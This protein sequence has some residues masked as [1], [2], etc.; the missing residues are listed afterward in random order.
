MKKIN[1]KDKEA[2]LTKHKVLIDA[3]NQLKDEFVGLDIIIDEVIDLVEPWY[4]FPD[5]QLRPS[6]INLFGMTGTG[7]TSLITRLFEILEM[8]SVLRFDT[9]E[10]VEKTEYQLSSTISGQIKKLKSDDARPIF[11]LDEFQLGRTID[12]HGAEIDRPNLR[13]V[14][15]LLDSGKFSIVEE[16]WQA[17]AV[18]S[19]YNKL[20]YL[21]EHKGLKAKNGKITKG[22]KDWELYFEYNDKEL[23]KDDLIDL[24]SY[25]TNNGI[26]PPNELYSLFDVSDR[27]FSERE[28]AKFLLTLTNEQSTLK[29]VE[30]VMVNASKA[31]EYDFSNSIIFI[32]GNLDGA[33]EMSH[34][35]D[36]DMDADF[37]YE[38]TKKIT[39][40]DIKNSLTDLYRPEQVS[41]L[42][43]N[44]IIYR[45]FNSDTYKDLIDLELIK[46]QNKINKKFE[47]DINFTDKTK[48]LIYKEGVFATQGVRP[49]FSTITSLIETKI[50]RVIIDILK[51][52]INANVIKWDTNN[53]K[54]KF[55]LTIDDKKTFEYELKLKVDNLRKSIGDDIQ[56]LV[57]V[58]ES[59]HVITAVYGMNVCPTLAVSKTLRDGG[60][61]QTDFPDWDT[62]E[63]LE[64]RLIMLL[65]GYAAEKLIFG[66][67]NLTSGSFSDLEKTTAI[68]LAMVKD[69]GMNGTPLQYAQ[70]DFRISGTALNDE[71]LDKIAEGIVK[72][73]LRKTEKILTDNKTL[74]LKM[75]EF[76]TK[77]SKIE[78]KQIK[79]MVKKYGSDGAPTY[80][81]KE[82]YYNFKTLL[83]NEIKNI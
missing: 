38:Y 39:I 2:I 63:L 33:Y 46:I 8:K 79:K 54:T 71:G 60:F 28:M 41:R 9:G 42:G 62:K 25:Y 50:G 36:A 12:E 76:L 78:E 29:F 67:E 6:I 17:Q 37:L 20:Q 32:I 11:I 40:S 72:E 27:F 47:I 56:A 23:D 68:A 4:L 69:Y 65:G 73:A 48:D 61:T 55:I 34:D 83:K 82:N 75:G 80:K 43:N 35:M 15:D 24:K 51:N 70:A 81:T 53:S 31:V 13:V 58:H 66:E 5:A 19:I 14:W 21:I 3:K 45:S 64:K 57:G 16:S 18:Q 22:Q 10:W 30:E 7:K 44:Y 77:N 74:L 49:I 1:K 59:G 52:K 26:I